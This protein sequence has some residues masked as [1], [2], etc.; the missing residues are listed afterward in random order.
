M[1]RLVFVLTTLFFILGSCQHQSEPGGSAAG[2]PNIR[3]ELFIIGGGHRPKTMIHDLISISGV[4]S[5]GYVAILPMASSSPDTAAYYAARQ[6]REQEI[7]DIHI[8]NIQSAEEMRPEV[9]DSLKNATMIYISG[10]SQSRFMDIANS[11]VLEE[12]IREAYHRGA[13]IAGTSAGAAVMSEKMITG[14]ERKHPEYTGNFRTIEANN[15]ILESGLELIPE[16]II[17]QHFIQRMRLNRLISAVLGN[18]DR[19]GIGIDESTAILVDGNKARVYGEGQ[20]V[21][22]RSENEQP[23]IREGLLGGELSMF[24]YLPGES[25]DVKQ[26]P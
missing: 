11:T 24:L 3:G 19:L 12:S 15:I 5:A 20:V 6:F 21:V 4:D 1:Y 8:F 7:D 18:P 10:G 2:H 9:M 17:D 14:D 25:F 26:K 16:A 23:E 13:T 22:L